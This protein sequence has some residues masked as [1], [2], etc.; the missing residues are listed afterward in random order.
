MPRASCIWGRQ[1]AWRLFKVGIVSLPDRA[2]WGSELRRCRPAH[3]ELRTERQ[4]FRPPREPAG[5][6]QEK[7]L[8]AIFLQDDY[9][10]AAANCHQA[11]DL[12]FHQINLF[13]QQGFQPCA[14]PA[15]TP[16]WL[17]DPA[18]HGGDKDHS[19]TAAQPGCLGMVFHDVNQAEHGAQNAQRRRIAVDSTPGQQNVRCSSR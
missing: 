14:P 19:N 13:G 7:P 3:G 11:F 2:G 4:A 17:P 5:W 18:V 9:G 15:E 6:D 10:T 1:L 16:G 12:H 8:Q